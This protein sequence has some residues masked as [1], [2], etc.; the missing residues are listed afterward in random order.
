MDS[1][2]HSGADPT[3]TSHRQSTGE[4]DAQ[5]IADFCRAQGIKNVFMPELASPIG[6]NDY[7]GYAVG[8]DG[9]LVKS[10]VGGL[11]DASS[12][13][14]SLD[15]EGVEPDSDLSGVEKL[16][17]VLVIE[18]YGVMTLLDGTT[19]LHCGMRSRSL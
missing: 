2:Q 8:M 17:F 11:G 7:P 3:D 4:A 12:L 9:V 16:P 10:G 18:K 6:A 13:I 14:Q 15:W 19:S 1:R 5:T